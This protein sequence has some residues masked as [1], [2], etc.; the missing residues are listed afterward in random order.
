MMKYKFH[1]SQLSWRS[2]S[3]DF[4]CILQS[5]DLSDFWKGMFALVFLLMQEKCKSVKV[6]PS[7]GSRAL[8]PGTINKSDT[9]K[10]SLFL[11][12]I[13]SIVKGSCR[14]IL[15]EWEYN[16]NM[17]LYQSFPPDKRFL[18]VNIRCLRRIHFSKSMQRWYCS[19]IHSQRDVRHQ[20]NK[21]DA[22]PYN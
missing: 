8:F 21:A 13:R 20:Q 14:T 3:F 22:A 5:K 16:T 9:G 19:G 4:L 10:Q 17:Y 15:T 18:S 12:T 7:C 1:F 2:R 6:P 11:Q